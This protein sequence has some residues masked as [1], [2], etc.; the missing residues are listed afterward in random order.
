[1]FVIEGKV[2][3]FVDEFRARAQEFLEGCTGDDNSSET[4]ARYMA[5]ELAKLIVERSDDG[6]GEDPG[7]GETEDDDLLRL[8]YEV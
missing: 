5:E 6:S 7:L 4:Q 8:M 1:M 3:E 2:N